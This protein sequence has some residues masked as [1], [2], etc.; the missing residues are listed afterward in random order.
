M[1]SG[2]GDWS[3]ERVSTGSYKLTFNDGEEYIVLLTP[4]SGDNP[5][6]VVV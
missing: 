4:T 3:I 2:S 5:G 6:G 1:Q